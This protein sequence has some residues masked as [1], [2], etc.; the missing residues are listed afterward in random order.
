MSTDLCSCLS[1]RRVA[2]MMH[3]RMFMSHHI[4]IKCINTTNLHVL[5]DFGLFPLQLS[6]QALAG[7]HTD[8]LESMDTDR[9]GYS[10]KR[11]MLVADLSRLPATKSWGSCYED[12]LLNHLGSS[13]T[14][15]MPHRRQGHSLPS[16]K[17]QH[18]QQLSQQTSSRAKLAE[19]AMSLNHASS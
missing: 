14:E 15:D 6:W 4:F 1:I 7:K 17:M 9:V 2:V 16:A 12:Q 3:K 8:R 10:S 11:L 19:W 13:P 18:I 5:A